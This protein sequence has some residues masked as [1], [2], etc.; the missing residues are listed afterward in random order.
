MTKLSLLIPILLLFGVASIPSDAQTLGPQ[1]VSVSSC[2]TVGTSYGRYRFTNV[3]KY[4]IEVMA[5]QAHDSQTNSPATFQLFPQDSYISGLTKQ[6][7]TLYWACSSPRKP[8]RVSS[9]ASPL[10]NA[11]DVGCT[12]SSAG[13]ALVKSGGVADPQNTRSIAVVS[14]GDRF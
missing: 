7:A 12:R 1:G 3:C 5:T 9:H 6:G 10:W 2:V 14:R 13:S 4:V 11:T 8:T